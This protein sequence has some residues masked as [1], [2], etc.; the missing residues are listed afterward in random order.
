MPHLGKIEINS[1]PGSAKETYILDQAMGITRRYNDDGDFVIFMEDFSFRCA[2]V[3]QL[4]D[5]VD[6]QEVLDEFDK[7]IGFL[8]E[9][10]E[11]DEPGEFTY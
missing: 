8:H 5:G 2:S 7:F 1:D 10:V 9:R 4:K 3:M 11:T 6:V